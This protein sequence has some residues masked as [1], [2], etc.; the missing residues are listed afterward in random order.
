MFVGSN[1][2]FFK[3]T[4]SDKNYDPAYTKVP[5]IGDSKKSYNIAANK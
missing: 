4:S 5:E 2:M 3:A 1:G